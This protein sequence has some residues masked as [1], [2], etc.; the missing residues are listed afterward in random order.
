MS[1]SGYLPPICEDGSM[2]VDGGYLNAVPADVMREFN[3]T[4]TVISVD[5]SAEMVRNY[6]NYGSHLNGWWLLWNS[7][8]PFVE[9]VNVP[10]MTDINDTL[11]WVSSDRH[12]ET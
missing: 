10:S 7:L 1:L 6:Y 5:V 4:H 11:R 12:R 3:G 8:N 9:T 2:L